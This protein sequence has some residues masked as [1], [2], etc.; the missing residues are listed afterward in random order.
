MKK[1]LF[2]FGLVCA[3]VA[4]LAIVLAGV[5]MI[6][7]L[8]FF[9]VPNAYLADPLIKTLLTTLIVSVGFLSASLIS[10]A[11]FVYY[12]QQTDKV[13]VYGPIRRWPLTYYKNSLGF[14]REFFCYYY[15]NFSSTARLSIWSLST[16][17]IS[18]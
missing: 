10:L 7:G 17:C 2:M 12:T 14:P 1:N 4:T 11:R 5:M 18:W 16:D 15:F 3:I 6:S 8:Y 13:E 9:K